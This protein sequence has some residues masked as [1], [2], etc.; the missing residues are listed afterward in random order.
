MKAREFAALLALSILCGCAGLHS[1]SDEEPA[2]ARSM[3]TH[4]VDDSHGYALL[5]GLLGD[6]KDVSKLLIIK[7]ERAELRDLIRAISETT[8]RAHAQLEKLAKADRSLNIKDNG[9]PPAE[10]EA[11][12]TITKACAKELLTESGKEFEVRLLLNQN[13]ALLYGVHLAA[14]ALKGETKQER[15]Q[16][17]R[18]LSTD[19][20]SF[21]QRVTTM[22]LSNY[23][24]PQ[25]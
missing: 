19:L 13:E 7:R 12:K 25:K 18:Q 24:W 11:R 16:F 14:A 4:S 8:G 6:E 22:L 3:H 20:T 1:A 5:F 2:Q 10:V 9:L 21:Q 15:A 23:D 17:L